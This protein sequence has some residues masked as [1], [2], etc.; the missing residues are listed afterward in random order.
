MRKNDQE[1][2]RRTGVNNKAKHYQNRKLKHAH[3]TELLLDIDVEDRCLS[4][5]DKNELIRISKLERVMTVAEAD[6]VYAIHS[7]QVAMKRKKELQEKS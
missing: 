5:I 6:I 3:A 4:A 2:R 7:N 1:E